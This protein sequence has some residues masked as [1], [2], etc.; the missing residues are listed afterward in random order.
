VTLDHQSPTLDPLDPDDQSA[1]PAILVVDD[2]ASYRLLLSRPLRQWGYQ[3]FEA[4]DGQEAL[5]LLKQEHIHLVISDWEMPELNGPQ[6]CHTIR[7]AN[8]SWYVYFILVT[9]RTTAADLIAGMEA[10]ADDFLT[11]PINPQELRVR[12]RAGERILK[13]ESRLEEQNLRLKDAYQLIEKDL[14]AA[15]VLQRSLLPSTNHQIPHIDCQWFF[16][17]S[18]FVSGDMHNYFQLDQHHMGFYSVDVSGHGVKP[19]MVSVAVSRLLSHGSYSGLLKKEI[20]EPPYYELTSPAEVVSRLNEQFQMTQEYSSYFTMVY[21]VLNLDTG[22][23]LLTRAGHPT[24]LIVHQNGDIEYLSEGDLP[25]GIMEHADYYNYP[26]R[27]LA[28]SRMYLYTDGI[29]ECEKDDGTLYGE[30]QLAAFLQKRSALSTS[31]TLQQLQ[32]VLKQWRG[33]QHASFDDDVSMLVLSFQPPAH[34]Q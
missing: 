5:D 25:V 10:G 12:L 28:G 9:A 19:A 17:P 29:T 33:E 16:L 2:S 3:V 14:Q 6:L 34:I 1:H 31:D 22:E 11:K 32:H 18:M 23:G 27:L 20:S 30:D 4:N 15:A 8:L 21:G 26:F 24:P 13:L 7:H